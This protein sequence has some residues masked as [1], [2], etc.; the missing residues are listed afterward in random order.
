[1]KAIINIFSD[2]L[3]LIYPNICICCDE[4]LVNSEKILCSHCLADIPKTNFNDIRQNILA[5]MFWGR[6]QIEGA[7]SLLY[8]RAES[9]YRKVLHKLKYEGQQDIGTQL[10]ILLG[11]EL[12][13]TEMN[14]IDYLIPVPLHPKR[15]RRRGFNQSEIIANGVSKVLDKPVI[16]NVVKRKSYNLSQTEKGR[17]DRWLNVEGIFDVLAPNFLDN[18]RILIIDDIITTGSTIEACVDAINKASDCKIY[19]CSVAFTN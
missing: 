18:K 16:N 3:N 15:L 6:I 12:V 11:N 9:R 2:F 10:G 4:K 8:F 17:Y 13:K 7:T 19:I 5:E 1:M 14:T